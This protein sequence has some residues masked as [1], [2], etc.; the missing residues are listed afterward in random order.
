MGE[1]PKTMVFVGNCYKY[2]KTQDVQIQHL[3]SPKVTS[4][5]GA[6]RL[7]LSHRLRDESTPPG[8]NVRFSSPLAPET[9]LRHVQRTRYT[10][11][12][13]ITPSL[14]PKTLASRQCRVCQL[15]G[16]T[17]RHGSCLNALSRHFDLTSHTSDITTTHPV[18]VS[19]FQ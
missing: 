17:V 9:T 15:L 18:R 10:T 1:F 13:A 2:V 8:P 19:T 6:P 4:G 12:C 11:W 14:L 5:F 16:L 7:E 3:M